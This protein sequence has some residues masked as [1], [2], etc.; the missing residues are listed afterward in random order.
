MKVKDLMSR[1]IFTADIN[2][3]LKDIAEKLLANNINCVIVSSSSK[4]VAGIITSSD[5]FRF[6]FPDYNE[7]RE[8]GEYLFDPLSIEQ[9]VYERENMPAE[10]LMTKF[11]EI[12]NEDSSVIQAAAIMKSFKI[13]QLPVIG[14]GKLIGIITIKNILRSFVYK[15]RLLNY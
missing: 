8:H 12:I 15:M 3:P 4:D 14:N 2:T 5:L 7:I 6:L 9:R 13:K 10:S 11:P 1:N